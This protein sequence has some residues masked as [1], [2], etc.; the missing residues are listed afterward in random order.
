MRALRHKGAHLDVLRRQ[1][2][3]GRPPRRDPFAGAVQRIEDQ[4]C[5]RCTLP[6][7]RK[8][9]FAP[10]QCRFQRPHARLGRRYLITPLP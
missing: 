9:P 6:F 1:Q 2:H 10:G 7:L 4:S 8:I 5:C 3:N